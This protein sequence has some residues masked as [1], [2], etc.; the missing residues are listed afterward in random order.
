MRNKLQITILV[1]GV[2]FCKQSIAQSL[3]MYS[4][5][6]YNMVNINPGYAGSRNVPSLSAIWR[7]QWVGLP[8]S[9]STKSFSYDMASKDN[10]NGFG[11]QLFDDKYV[12][13]IKRT[14]VNLY[15]NLKIPVSERG[16]LSLG[17]KGGVYNDTKNLNNTY[18]GASSTYLTDVAYA[19]NLNQIV[20]LMGAGVYYNDDKF[21]A[22]FSAPDMIVFSK[23]K[24]Y[25]ADKSLFQ[26]NEIHY[27]LTAGYSFDVNEEVQV[28]PSFLLKAT[29][30]APLEVDLNTNVWLKNT[31][32]LGLS[33]RTAES[34][35]GMA[36][37]QLTP[38]VRLGYAYDMP[39]KRPN[40]H[41][42]FLRYEFG[43][44]FPNSNSYKLF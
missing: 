28:K 10:K 31:V 15:Y 34:V 13:Y 40:S 1:L 6:M 12:N 9:P 14:G 36:E 35:L 19:S 11:V 32:G 44:L 42:L 29:S 21:Y 7:E 4:Q 37:V 3:P 25:S 5:Y 16:V 38:Q 33:Y 41:E 23:V 43:R 24:N 26:V 22:G 20:P 18:L 8:G 17:L 39:F 27:F 30:G 2:I